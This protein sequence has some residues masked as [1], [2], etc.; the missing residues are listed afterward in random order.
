MHVERHSLK[1][2]LAMCTSY[3]DSGTRIP[4]TIALTCPGSRTR[5]IILCQYVNGSLHVPDNSTEEHKT[6]QR[7][8]RT[9]NGTALPSLLQICLQQ[10]LMRA[11]SCV[12]RGTRSEGYTRNLN[13]RCIRSCIQLHAQ[14]FPSTL[15]SSTYPRRPRDPGDI[16]FSVYE[17]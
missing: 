13:L 14:R 2:A 9:G 1:E 16:V 5:G 10:T 7:Q 6:P 15:G 3:G 8:A 4:H 11:N 12:L 17:A